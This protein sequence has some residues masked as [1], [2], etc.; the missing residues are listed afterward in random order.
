[1]ERWLGVAKHQVVRAFFALVR[2]AI[3]MSTEPGTKFLC[4]FVLA[5]ELSFNNE[6]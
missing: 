3:G 5:V 2:L 1:M 6:K 4:F